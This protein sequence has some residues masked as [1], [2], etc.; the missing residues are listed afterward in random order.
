MNAVVVGAGLTGLYELYRLREAG[1]SVQ[2]FEAGGGVAGTWYWNRYPGCCFDSESEIYSYSFSDEL[3]QEWSW[4]HH[5]SLQPDNE[6]YY[7]YVCDRFDLWPHIRLNTEVVGADWDEATGEWTV[8]VGGGEQVQTRYLVLAVGILSAPARFIPAIPGAGETG[9]GAFQGEAYHTSNWPLEEVTVAGR[10]VAVIGSGSSGVQITPILAAQADQLTSFQRTP[11]YCAPLRNAPVSEA[12]QQEWKSDYQGILDEAKANPRG[13]RYN[14]DPRKA[15]EVE[16][17]ERWETY[18]RLW[19]RPGFAKWMENFHDITSDPAASAD[20][21]EFVRGK[22]RERIS[23]PAVAEKLVPKDHPFGAKRLPMESGYYE[24]FAQDNVALVDVKEDP[25]E[26]IEAGGVRTVSGFHEADLIV[27]ATGF[28]SVTGGM[29]R[30]DIRGV[31]GQT[32]KEAWSEGPRGYLNLMTEGFPNMFTAVPRAFCNYPRCAELVAEW[33]ADCIYAMEAR[34]ARSIVPTVEAEDAWQARIEA[35]AQGLIF[36]KADSWF[37][38]G[39]IPGKK[40]TFML[41]PGSLPQYRE[42]ITEAAAA[43]YDGF[44][45]A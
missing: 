30:I 18:E 34:G 43:D 5:Y 3:L 14:P 28:D 11:T 31:G 29:T 25:I 13:Y 26:A 33:V 15:M 6:R 37:N 38:G 2:L 32:L 35:L 9:S 27:Y 4:K 10:K 24:A 8:R 40:R 19:Q 45:V 17:G 22:I 39:N 23:S 41:F 16:R 1:L 36:E 7:N 44:V 42:A 12:T 21:T 20:Y